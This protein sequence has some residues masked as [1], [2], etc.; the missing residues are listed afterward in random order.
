M[1]TYLFSIFF[2]NCLVVQAFDSNVTFTLDEMKQHSIVARASGGQ[3]EMLLVAA[4]I[5]QLQLEASKCDS[6]SVNPTTFYASEKNT[7]KVSSKNCVLK[8][9]KT[10][11]CAA[12]FNAR[13]ISIN[14]RTPDDSII[15]GEAYKVCVQASGG[16]PASLPPAIK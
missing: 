5:F 7:F 3:D 10:E 4:R 8:N 16:T 11:E 2:L 1:K 15:G 12:G 6:V 9:K 13:N 14:P